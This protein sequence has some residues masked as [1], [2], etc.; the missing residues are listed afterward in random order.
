MIKKVKMW[1]KKPKK[2][3][4]ENHISNIFISVITVVE[5]KLQE[6]GSLIYLGP[7]ISL[8]NL[9]WASQRGHTFQNYTKHVNLSDFFYWRIY[10]IRKGQLISKKFVK[11]RI[12]PKNERMNSFLIVCDVFSFVFWKNPRPEKNVSRFTDL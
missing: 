12:L 6:V 1:I 5:F 2:F 11:P 4:L 7:I 8:S 10:Y 3:C 9:L